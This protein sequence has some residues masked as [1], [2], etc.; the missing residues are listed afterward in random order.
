MK[1][2]LCENIRVSQD[3][4]REKKIAE[5]IKRNISVNEAL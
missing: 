4:V 3:Y 2:F 5:L 1:V